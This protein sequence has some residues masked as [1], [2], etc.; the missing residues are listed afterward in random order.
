[1]ER[2]QAAYTSIHKTSDGSRISQNRKA[3][4]GKLGHP[5]DYHEKAFDSVEIPAVVETLIDQGVHSSYINIINTIYNQGVHSSYINIIN[6]IY[7]QGV[8]S[9]YIN[10]I[11]TIYNQGTSI[12]RL[13]KYSNKINTDRRVRQG[14]T[15]SPKFFNTTLEGIFRRSDWDR[16]GI[17]IN[18]DHLS[19]LRF[20][21]GNV[22][23]TNNAE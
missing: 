22:L 16:K 1:M 4:G 5:L 15:V 20:A 6:T 23:T 13:H 11:N 21:D 14:D 19:H 8:H 7:N 10:I 17:N 9:S 2:W 3:R 18:G 12:V